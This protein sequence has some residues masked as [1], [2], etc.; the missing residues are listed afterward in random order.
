MNINPQTMSI[1]RFFGGPQEQFYIPAYQRRYSW[2]K[3]QILDMYNDIISLDNND[4]HLLG[5]VVFLTSVHTPG[6]NRLELVD[7]QQRITSLTLFFKAIKER[8]IILGIQTIAN[9]IDQYLHAQE[10]VDKSS[11]KLLLGDLDNPDYKSLME[12]E[13]IDTIKNQNLLDN[14]NYLYSKINLLE[15]EELKSL[16]SKLINSVFII[17]LDIDAAKD[18]YKL[19]ETINNRGLSLSATDIIKNFLLGKAS[20]IDDKTLDKVRNNWKGVIINLDNIKMDNFFRQLMSSI[21]EKK[22]SNNDLIEEFKKYYDF[23]ISKDDQASVL[24]SF[25][26]KILMAS[27]I[28]SKIIQQNFQSDLINTHLDNLAR[29]ESLPSY[30]FLLNIFQRDDLKDKEIVSILQIIE[31]FMLRRTI[32]EYRTGELDVIFSKLV[33]LNSKNIIKTMQCELLKDT[34]S[35]VEFEMKFPT[36]TFTT[37]ANR[38]KY[39]LEQFEYDAIDHQNEF[40]LTRGQELHLEHII[41]QKITSKKFESWENYLGLNAHIQHKEYLNRI[42]NFTLLGQELNIKASNHPFQVKLEQYKKSN[43]TLTQTIAEN[44]QDFRF[45]EVE[46]RSLSMAKKAVEIWK[47]TCDE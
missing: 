39:I 25:S 15:S 28:Y 13:D 45:E 22:V 37:K 10:T 1:A 23:L 40:R 2:G 32:C 17:R 11:N 6:I 47:I 18:A 3:T 16:Y 29:V 5:N 46:Q 21:L 20:N 42:G 9:N 26:K 41:P 24:V 38:A 27:E 7:G 8:S 30:I 4:T 33:K 14:Y 35:D 36:A 43:I 34:P 44:Y 12:W 31:T 19:F